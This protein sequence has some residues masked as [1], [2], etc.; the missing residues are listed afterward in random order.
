MRESNHFSPSVPS[1]TGCAREEEKFAVTPCSYLCHTEAI[2]RK[3]KG[4]RCHWIKP[5]LSG[6]IQTPLYGQ[7]V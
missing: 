2:I 4:V 6:S 7:K 5:P 1:V 3:G